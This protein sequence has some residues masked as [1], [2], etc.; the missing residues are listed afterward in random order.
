MG[1]LII[2]GVRR[3][4]DM[5]YVIDVEGTARGGI[6]GLVVFGVRGVIRTRGSQQCGCWSY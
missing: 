5:G 4:V 2:V 6:L 3:G 1:L